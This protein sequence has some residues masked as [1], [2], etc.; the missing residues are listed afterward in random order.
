MN[1]HLFI[2]MNL[3]IDTSCLR[4]MYKEYIFVDNRD[5]LMIWQLI[6]LVKYI[7]N[8]YDLAYILSILV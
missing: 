2:D 1:T 8:C 4:I 6:K 3:N 7:I 5:S